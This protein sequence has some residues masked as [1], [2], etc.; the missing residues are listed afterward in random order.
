MPPI[1][2]IKSSFASGELAPSLRSRVDLNLYSKGATK[3]KNLIVHP[4]G[5]IS[6]RAGLHYIAT[7]KTPSTKKVRVIPFEFSTQQTYVL[8]FGDLYIRFYTDGTQL[9]YDT[10]YD[11]YTKLMLHCDGTDGSTTFTDES[12]KTMTAVGTAQLDTAQKKFGTASLMLDGDSDYVTT[13]DHDDWNFGAGDFTIDFWVRF[14]AGAIGAKQHFFTQNVT[15]QAESTWYFGKTAG[16]KLELLEYDVATLTYG[17]YFT[18]TSAWSLAAATWYYI[19]VVRNGANCYMF[20]DGVSQALTETKPFGTFLDKDSVLYIGRSITGAA[21]YVNGWMD[22]IRISKGIARH[23]AN[24]T[25]PSAAYT[26]TAVYE[27]ATPY[28]QD[29]LAELNYT[30]SADVLYLTHPGHAPRQLERLG[31]TNWQLNLYA[32][33]NGPFMVDNTNSTVT[34]AL[35]ATSGTGKTLTAVG[36]TFS[37]MHVGSLW[38]LR[39]YMEGQAVTQALTSSTQTPG[40]SCG[41]TWR[42]ITHGTWTGTIRIE[43]S[44]DSGSTWINL[45]EFSSAADYNAD[46]Y[47]TEDMSDYAVPFLVRVR[48]TAYTSGTINVNLTTDPFYHEGIAEITAVAAGGATATVDIQRASGSTAT[49]ADWA[50]G[51]WG[52]YRGWPAVVEFH[53]EDR[54]M[55]ANTDGEPD[56]YWLTMVGNYTNFARSSPLVDSDAISSP[57]PSRKVNGINGLVPLSEMIALTLSNEISVRSSSGPLSPTTVYNKIHGWE[58]SYGIR[59]LII[60]N[61][62]VYI[63]STGSIVRDLGYELYSETFTG[64]D[65][66]ILSNHLFGGYTIVEMAYQQNPDRLV[67]TIRSDG[68]LLSMTY[69]PEQEVIA[70]SWHDTNSG[71]DLFE[72]VCCIRGDG[73]DEVWF[74]VNRGGT[75]YIERMTQRQ[76]STV[77]ANQFFVDCGTTS[78][79][80]QISLMTGLTHLNGKTV[81][82]LADGN[83]LSQQEV[84]GSSIALGATYSTVQVGLPYTSDVETLNVDANLTDGTTQGRKIKIS[85]LVLR[86]LNSRGGEL[87][88]DFDTLYDIQHPTDSTSLD[89]FST[90]VKESMAGGYTDGGRICIRQADPLPMTVLAIIPSISIGGITSI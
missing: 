47:G 3:L 36:F 1:V 48:C 41:G 78:S 65:R 10:G 40:I 52:D 39:H 55:F 13:P 37:T 85:Q 2:G 9:E 32:F 80:A 43:K 46:T 86:F 8:E 89:L 57:V 59:P 38:K 51:S 82:I 27:I 72:S 26:T 5:G 66:S 81:A 31:N 73:Y 49:T 77:P 34:L 58:G 60:G 90:D 16:D 18:M 45:R 14:N 71:T 6:N 84:T 28:T 15:A 4:H 33:E 83:V 62:A 64:L 22:E 68:L 53:P 56:T 23:T 42:I 50:E 70:W 67:W 11:T 88:P 30:Q 35:S 75:R 76:A 74:V 61:R 29:D 17:A 63:Q 54:L 19:E 20:I 7:S 24:F 69:M 79:T 44:T 12:G 21:G 25:P 87:G